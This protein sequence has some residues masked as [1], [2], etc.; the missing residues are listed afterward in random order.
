MRDGDRHRDDPPLEDEAVVE[1]AVLAFLIAEHPTAPT[2]AELVAELSGD[3]ES[4]AERDAVERA[5]R[6]LAAVGLA[7]HRGG[8]VWPTRAALRFARIRR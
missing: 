4:F 8:F 5:V 3:A 6:D 7:H 1:G 2:L